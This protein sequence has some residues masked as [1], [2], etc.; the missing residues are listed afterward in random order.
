MNSTQEDLFSRQIGAVGKKTM[1]QL[2]N[3]KLMVPE[4]LHLRKLRQMVL[5]T[6]MVMSF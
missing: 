5:V 1:E 4:L 2:L 3:L 6:H